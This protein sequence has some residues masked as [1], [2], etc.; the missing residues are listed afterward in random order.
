MS[1]YVSKEQMIK[2]SE[3]RESINVILDILENPRDL[4]G[5]EDEKEIERFYKSVYDLGGLIREVHELNPD[6]GCLP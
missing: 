4:N 1:V 3:I 5:D 6:P 2:M